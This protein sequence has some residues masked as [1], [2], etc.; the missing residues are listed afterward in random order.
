MQEGGEDARRRKGSKKEERKQEGGEDARRRTG[1]EK[2]EMMQEGGEEARRRRGSKKEERVNVERERLEFE[3]LIRIRLI[4]CRASASA[5]FTLAHSDSSPALEKRASERSRLSLR[6]CS[7]SQA[8]SL[9]AKMGPEPTPL[10]M[11]E[12]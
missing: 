7:V 8:M 11:C 10:S 3:I 9:A 4:C 2:E 1:C 12:P 5:L 6:K